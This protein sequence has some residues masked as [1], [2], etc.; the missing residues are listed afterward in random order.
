MVYV[1][2]ADFMERNRCP[3]GLLQRFTT[4]QK[5]LRGTV[6]C[7]YIPLLDTDQ[8]VKNTLF[9]TFFMVQ[10]IVMTHGV[11]L[12]GQDYIIDN[13][14]SDKKAKPMIVVMPA[15]HTTSNSVWIAA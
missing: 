6:V 8:T 14:I 11:Q 15:G 13:L 9:F 3:M 1:P 2:G 5:P 12:A 7:T 10:W 4:I